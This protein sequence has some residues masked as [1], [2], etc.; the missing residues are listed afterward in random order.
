MKKEITQ[1][2]IMLNSI[3]ND[4]KNLQEDRAAGAV[5]DEEWIKEFYDLTKKVGKLEA[6]MEMEEEKKETIDETEGA[7]C[8]KCGDKV[9]SDDN[10]IC[11]NCV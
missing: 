5:N 1:R 2:E 10:S 7:R 9:M 11:G 3:Y 8:I 4:F 6:Y